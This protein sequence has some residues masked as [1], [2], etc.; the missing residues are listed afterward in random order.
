M[1]DFSVRIEIKQ[2]PCEHCCHNRECRT[3]YPSLLH[4]TY[5]FELPGQPVPV[6]TP[7]DE[8][9][10]RICN[11]HQASIAAIEQAYAAEIAAAE[12]L[13]VSARALQK[14][15]TNLDNA[16]EQAHRLMLLTVDSF[17]A[18]DKDRKDITAQIQSELDKHENKKGDKNV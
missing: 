1:A 5:A 8:I 18:P 4:S 12:N 15:I 6:K 9:R 11:R 3:A 17:F 2:D 14:R 7:W 16:R 10:D 13:F